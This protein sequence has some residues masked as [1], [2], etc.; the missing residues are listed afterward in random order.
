[1]NTKIDSIGNNAKKIKIRNAGIDF[2]RIASMYSIIVHHIVI[3]G[4][5]NIKY[6]KYRELVLMNIIGFWHVS[7]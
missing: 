7:T 6:N 3:H 2:I 1:M 5:V 4:K